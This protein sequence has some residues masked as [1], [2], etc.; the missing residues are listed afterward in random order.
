[1]KNNLKL[2]YK[3]KKKL[4][5]QNGKAKPGLIKISKFTRNGALYNTI[6][7][8]EFELKR[9]SNNMTRN[10]KSLVLN[11]LDPHQL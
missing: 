2:V 10:S 5:H 11:G 7:T 4:K 1:M 6:L 3:K 9:R 8:K